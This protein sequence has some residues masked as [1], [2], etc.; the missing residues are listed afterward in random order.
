M[1][2]P[3]KKQ[4]LEA[5]KTSPEAREALKKLFPTIINDDLDLSK[6]KPAS[7]SEY[8]G[9]YRI[10]SKESSIK[11]CNDSFLIKLSIYKNKFMLNHNLNWELVTT[12]TGIKYL[13]PT[14]KQWLYIVTY[15]YVD[16]VFYCGE[17]IDT[18]ELGAFSTRRLAEKC[19][20]EFLEKLPNGD[21]FEKLSTDVWRYDTYLGETCGQNR[22]IECKKYILDEQIE[23]DWDRV[24]Y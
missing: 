6:L 10:F 7:K 15:T 16:W 21:K 17:S 4:I 24:P 19:I 11:A 20:N 12:K 22:E 5:A 8:D 23:L 14:F 1:N 18:I 9:L 2:S 3:T 13:I